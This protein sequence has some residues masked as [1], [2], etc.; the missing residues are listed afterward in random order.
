MGPNIGF[1]GG[2]PPGPH[3]G[4]ISP[5][6]RQLRPRIRLSP[7]LCKEARR[8]GRRGMSPEDV[9]IHLSQPIEQ[10]KLAMATLRTRNRGRSRATLNVTI[11]AHDYV[12]AQAL[13]GE[14]A[15]ATVDRLLVE[16]AFRRAFGRR[17]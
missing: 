2:V 10:V 15:W 11:D 17:T 3:A 5:L 6:T 9:A 1:S 14:S 4:K 16:L 7:D 8:L 12:C 13:A